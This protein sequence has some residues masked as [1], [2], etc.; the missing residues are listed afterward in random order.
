[1]SGN[2]EMRFALKYIFLERGEAKEIL[3]ARVREADIL[4]GKLVSDGSRLQIRV[5]QVLGQR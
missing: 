2:R 3:M 4:A 5:N 1:V